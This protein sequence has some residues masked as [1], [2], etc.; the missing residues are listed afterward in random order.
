MK[1]FYTKQELI[2]EWND[3]LF[4]EGYPELKSY[5]KNKDYMI[6]IDENIINLFGYKICN[7]TQECNFIIENYDVHS[8]DILNKDSVGLFYNINSI[9]NRP[10]SYLSWDDNYYYLG[11]Y[12]KKIAIYK[13]NLKDISIIK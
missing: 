7:N 5:Y 13:K 12:G 9:K 4:E 1:Y 10:Y 3:R 2:N 6:E 8:Y 11:F